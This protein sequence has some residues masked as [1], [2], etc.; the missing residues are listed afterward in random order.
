MV[1]W[2]TNP[3]GNHEVVGS[4]PG[5]AQWVK[6]SSIAVSCGICCR[7]SSD[8]TLLWLWC[9]YS[10]DWTPSLGTSICHGSG[11]REKGKK[12]KKKKYKQTKEER[13]KERKNEKGKGR[14]EG[15]KV[16]NKVRRKEWRQGWR[17][18]GQAN[19]NKVPQKIQ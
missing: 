14:N 1:Q 5:L 9:S 12:T 2:L 18:E 16:G 19:I 6:G 17:K 15:R 10:S 11:P 3:T 8:L 7:H 4:V 13:M